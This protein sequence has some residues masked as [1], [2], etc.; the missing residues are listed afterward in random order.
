MNETETQKYFVVQCIWCG[1][2]IREDKEKETTGVCLSCFYQ[3]LNNHL[4]A[5]RQAVYGEFVSDR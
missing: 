2:R 3:I 4:H 5:Q 1:A